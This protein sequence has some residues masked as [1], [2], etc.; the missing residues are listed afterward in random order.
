MQKTQSPS[1][2]SGPRSNKKI[3][4][5]RAEDAVANK[6]TICTEVTRKVLSTATDG[7]S[8]AT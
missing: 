7:S 4:M 5:D 6:D 1:E 8:R 2:G 3:L